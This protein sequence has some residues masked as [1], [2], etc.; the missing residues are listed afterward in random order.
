[1]LE[2]TEG[3]APLFSYVDLE[4]PQLPL[5]LLSFDLQYYLSAGN[6]TQN[7]GAYIFKPTDQ[8]TPS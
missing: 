4:D 8:D 2:F 7:S 3:Q 6:E 1:M 5:Q